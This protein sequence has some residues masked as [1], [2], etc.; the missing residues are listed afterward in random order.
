MYKRTYH[1]DRT[2]STNLQLHP[3]VISKIRGRLFYFKFKAEGT[4]SGFL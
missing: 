4:S 3:P 2:I 1:L